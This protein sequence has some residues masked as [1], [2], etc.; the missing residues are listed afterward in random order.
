MSFTTA[1]TFVMAFGHPRDAIEGAELLIPA[2]PPSPGGGLEQKPLAA[3]PLA[4]VFDLDHIEFKD[5][6]AGGAHATA[7]AG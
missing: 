2:R 6:R 7:K 5:L 4:L 1:A 3:D